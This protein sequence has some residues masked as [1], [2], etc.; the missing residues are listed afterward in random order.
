MKKKTGWHKQQYIFAC[1]VCFILTAGVISTWFLLFPQQE[2]PLPLESQPTL[3][4][5]T[6]QTQV[7]LPSSYVISGGDHVFQTFNNC[8]PA[9]LSM[10]LSLLGQSVSQRTLGDALRPYQVSN[11][12]NDDK[13]VTLL[14]LALKAQEYGYVVYVRPAGSIEL[15]EQFVAADVPVITRTW[16]SPN[17]DIG[18][19]RVVKG[20]D[21]Q[22]GVLIQDDSLQG[23]D[24]EYSY[25]EFTELWQAFNF[26]FLVLVPT[27][28]NEQART[29]LANLVDESIAWESAL[30]LAEAQ[31]AADSGDAY[32]QFNAVVALTHLGRYEE[33]IVQYEQVED[34]LPKR[35]LW[36][37][38]EPVLAYFRVGKY[39]E[40]LEISQEIFNS[41]N[42]AY[43][44]LHWLRGQI[45]SQRGETQAAAESF[46]L[47]ERY[48][49]SS[50]WMRNIQ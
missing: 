15:L 38:I 27:E 41:Q 5:S 45:F 10:A 32:A 20:Y 19:Y 42:R 49:T 8:G 40:V 24:L 50:Y 36:Y 46:A 14:E 33:A 43:S 11:G 39:D 16:L 29:I 4:E 1:I 12:D 2:I 9:S 6:T 25:D 7:S 23:K 28:K 13:S 44:E 3:S 35:M 48:N 17:E 47:A 26:E 21:R 31:K 34:A 30:R 22:R 37:Q 18:H